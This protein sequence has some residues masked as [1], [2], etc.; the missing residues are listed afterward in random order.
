MTTLMLIFAVASQTFNL[1]PGLLSALCYTE[2]KHNVSAIHLDDGGADS[3]GVCQLQ[4]RSA[5]GIGFRGSEE[6]LFDPTLNVHYAAKYLRS[7]LDRYHGDIRKA[8]AAYN[9]GSWRENER[10]L[11][12]NRKYVSAVFKAW[13]EDKWFT[14]AIRVFLRTY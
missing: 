3:V 14:G 11:T 13:S 4:L 12:K 8:V 9:A 7:Q 1:P 6:D 2:S 10:G 5:R